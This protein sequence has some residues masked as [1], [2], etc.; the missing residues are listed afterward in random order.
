MALVSVI[1]EETKYL[2]KLY[3]ERNNKNY[4]KETR[5]V[6]TEYPMSSSR[7]YSTW[8]TLKTCGVYPTRGLWGRGDCPELEQSS[9]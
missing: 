8:V 1:K 5:G 3:E 7:V 9:N 2:R 6:E 4:Y